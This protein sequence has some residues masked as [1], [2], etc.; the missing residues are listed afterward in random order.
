MSDRSPTLI[1]GSDDGVYRFENVGETA[2]KVLDTGQVFR[3]RQ[4]PGLDGLFVTSES[5][6]YHS[7]DG[8]A[9]TELPVPET[10]VY[11]V[12]ADPD[13]ERLYA[14]TRPAHLFAADCGA[15]VPTGEQDWEAVP[16]FQELR[17]RT[18]WG[19]PRHDG[20]AQVR[21]LCTH[22]DT[23]DRL[24]AGIE[25]G[26]VHVSDDGGETWQSRRIEG[27]DAP[28]TDDIHH[29]ALP[30]SETVV[31]S[32]GSGLYRSSDA[33]RSWERLD[34]G[35]RQRY[36]REAFV[37]DGT[38]YAGGAPASSSSWEE[39]TDHALFECHESDTLEPVPS[40]APTEVALGWC[41]F[42]G[43]IL[44][45]AHRGTLLQR[46]SDGWEELGTVPTPGTLSGR[47]LPMTPF[48]KSD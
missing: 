47:Y 26:G 21:S 17:E 19:L 18:D 24:V 46:Q 16:G 2:E 45:V 15:G 3:I 27:F 1:A 36:F 10:E 13:G 30:D 14:G 8:Q 29:L 42:E 28:H 35:H 12:T 32:T 9:W 7:R 6:L 31:A 34:T 41:E 38:V 25:V 5:G 40:P 37:H 48:T 11:A 43:Q 22:P 39:D 4:F 33:G 23:P 44:A 20:I